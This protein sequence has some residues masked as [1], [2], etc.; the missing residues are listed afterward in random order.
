[1][2]KSIKVVLGGCELIAKDAGDV[3]WKILER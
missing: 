1:M 3:L 2:R